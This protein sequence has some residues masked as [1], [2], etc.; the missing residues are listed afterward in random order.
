[1]MPR[2]ATP[3]NLPPIPSRLEIVASRIDVC[4]RP[5]RILPSPTRSNPL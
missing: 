3:T 1:M 2:S 5:M 4:I